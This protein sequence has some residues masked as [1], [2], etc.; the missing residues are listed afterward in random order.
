MTPRE[1]VLAALRGNAV[2][3]PPVSFW[4]HFYHRESSASDLAQATL[5]NHRTYDWDWIKLNPRKHYHVEPWGVS[6]RYSGQNEKPIQESWPVH[7]PGDW[8]AISEKPH[9][10]GALGEQIE[11]VRLMREGL[12]PEVPLLQTVFTPLAIL[13][14]LVKGPDGLRAHLDTHPDQV[15]PA[16]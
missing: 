12:G 6:Y 14:E 2:D 1:R 15:R 9:D 13:R 11:A 3:R 5:E 8:A 16:Q 10:Q 7:E 4:G